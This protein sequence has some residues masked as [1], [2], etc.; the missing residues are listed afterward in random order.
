MQINL[1]AEKAL[2]LIHQ[3]CTVQVQNANIHNAR[4]IVEEWYKT[5]P[6]L[7]TGNAVTVDKRILLELAEAVLMCLDVSD[8]S[9]SL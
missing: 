8:K 1:T 4:R 5:Q 6:H 2:N 9:V 3:V 7:E